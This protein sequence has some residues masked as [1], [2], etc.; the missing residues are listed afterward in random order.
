MSQLQE[1]NAVLKKQVC[2]GE[3]GSC[4]KKA[5]PKCF[6]NTGIEKDLTMI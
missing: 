3:L 5:Y 4:G 6:H 2:V 1:D